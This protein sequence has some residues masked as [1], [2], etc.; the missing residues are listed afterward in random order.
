MMKGP[1]FQP[2][3]QALAKLRN[4][5]LSY[6]IFGMELGEHTRVF[7]RCGVGV[8]RDSRGSRFWRKCGGKRHPPTGK[9]TSAGTRRQ[10]E[11]SRHGVISTMTALNTPSK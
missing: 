5:T 6:R 1:Q 8:P 7:L 4:V 9:L 11:A 10:N 2:G 3:Q